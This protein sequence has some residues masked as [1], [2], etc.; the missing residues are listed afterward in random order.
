[1]PDTTL[2][3]CD[4]CKD[5][6]YHQNAKRLSPGK[7]KLQSDVRD[8]VCGILVKHKDHG[9]YKPA[10]RSTPWPNRCMCYACGNNK[11]PHPPTARHTTL[12]VFVLRMVRANRDKQGSIEATPPSDHV[13]LQSH[14]R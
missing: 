2:D 3:R 9:G 4:G 10:R 7:H 13:T 12:K 8:D 1:M 5:W 11:H 14:H 6:D